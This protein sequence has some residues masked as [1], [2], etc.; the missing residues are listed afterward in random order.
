MLCKKLLLFTITIL[1][2]TYLFAQKETNQFEK[3]WK[4]IDSLI[5]FQ[6]Q[7]KSALEK[8]N[9]L[10]QRALGKDIADQQI[11]C[12]IYKINL[13]NIDGDENPTKKIETLQAEI[14]IAYNAASKAILNGLIAQAYQHY[15]EAN[16]WKFYNRNKTTNYLKEDITT[17]SADDF[18]NI[19]TS[20]YLKSLKATE[21]LQQ[22]DIATFS[23][24][25]QKGNASHL[26]PTLYDLLAHNALDYFKTGEHQITKPA[27]PFIINDPK[28]FLPS[29]QFTKAS[30]STKDS[31]S[32]LIETIKLFQQLL[33]LHIAR[34][35][36]AALLTVDIERITW[37]KQ[38]GVMR[39]KAILYEKALKS[40]V[41]QYPKHPYNLQAWYL[42]ANIDAEKARKYSPNKDTANRYGF[43]KA[44]AIINPI[45]PDTSIHNEGSA[46]LRNLA[47][48]IQQKEISIQTE[49]VNSINKPFRALVNYKNIDTL[50]YRVYKINED[51]LDNGQ[52][53]IAYSKFI[54]MP[55]M[56][57]S[58]QWLPK[59]YDHQHHSVEIK[60]DGLPSGKYLL[61]FDTTHFIETTAA[62]KDDF[63]F[64]FIKLHISNIA[65]IHNDR[66]GSYV[67]DRETGEPLKNVKVT[68]FDN[69]DEIVASAT[70]NR[71][72]F[73]SLWKKKKSDDDDDERSLYA[74][75]QFKTD[76]DSLF[77][78]KE[79]N[80][81]KRIDNTSKE[82]PSAYLFTD[83]AIY[84]PGQ[85]LFFKAITIKSK[86][87]EHGSLYLQKEK[88]VVFLKDANNQIIDSIYCQQ[89]DYGSIAG[90]F[91]L[92]SS[93]LT[94]QFSITLKK[95][96]GYASFSVEEYKRPSFSISLK[97]PSNS[98]RLYDTIKIKGNATA[99]SGNTLDN[100]VVKYTINRRSNY[101]N[102][103]ENY[104]D[105]Y[106]KDKNSLIQSGDI[107]TDANGNFQ[108]E[109]LA[110]PDSG[111]SVNKK[112]TFDYSVEV[113]I[114]DKGG[115]TR[116]EKINVSVGYQ[117]YKLSINA[118]RNALATN[119]ESFEIKTT[120]YASIPQA[121]KVG[122]KIYPLITPERVIRNSFWSAAD[123]FVFSRK[124]YETYF[125]YDDYDN[126]LKKE[127][128]KL[129]EPIINA[130]FNTD[131]STIFHLPKQL[132]VGYYKIV[133]TTD[134]KS[135][136]PIKAEQFIQL[137]DKHQLAYPQTNFSCVLKNTVAP[138]E[139]AEFLT[140]TAYNKVHVFQQTIRG[141]GG[142]GFLYEKPIQ[143]SRSKG[144]ERIV[145]TP[146][147][148]DRGG[149]AIHEKFVKNGRVYA[150]EYQ[151][152]VPW[153]NKD[154]QINYASYRNKTEP[155]NKEKWTVTVKDNTGGKAAAEIV[156]T[157]YDASLDQ[158]KT[159]EFYRPNIWRMGR[160]YY[161]WQTG[162]G[163]QSTQSQN[164][165]LNNAQESYYVNYDYLYNLDNSDVFPIK[166]KSFTGSIAR[167]SMNDGV[168][169]SGDQIVIGYGS[170]KK[171]NQSDISKSKPLYVVDGVPIENFNPN[172]NAGD[173]ASMEVLND[174]ATKSI[175]GARAANGV[176]I[177][178]TKAAMA[179]QKT[180]MVIRKN[181]N[182]TAFFVP[183]LHADT[184]GNYTISF[185]MPDALT[186]WKW[187][188]F[189]HTKDLQFGVQSANIVSQ[190]TLMVQT[191]APRFLRE[192]DKLE[193]TSTISNLS[194][195]E[196]SGEVSL[197]LVDATTN[198]AVDG[199]FQN[200]FPK[201]YFTVSAKQSTLIKFPLTIPYN[202][203]K[204]MIWKV[205][206]TAGNFSDGEEKTIPIISNRQ[207][208]T[209]TMPILLRGDTTINLPFTKLLNQN[210]GSKTLSN[211]SVTV[212][213]TPNPVWTALQAL[214]YL[215][216]YPY[217]CA[218][219]TF[220]RFFGNVLASNLV[221]KHPA[222]KKVFAKW[223]ND[224]SVLQ[225]NLYK[226]EELKQTLLAETPWVLAAQSE[227]QQQK[228]IALLFDAVKMGN[229][230][231]QALEKLIQ[232]QDAAGWLPW[233]KGGRQDGYITNY[234]L[235]G[236][237]KL[238][239]GG[240]LT[241]AQKT[242]LQAFIKKGVE[243]VDNQ[244]V[245][246]Y[247]KIVELYKK[248]FNSKQTISNTDIDYL[249]M[250]S[251]WLA[252]IPLPTNA[253]T[254]YNYF[255]GQAK[256]Y[257]VKF[258]LYQQSL[259]GLA[260]L[261]NNE[262]NFV[263][264]NILPSITQ[265]AIRNNNGVYWKENYTHHWYESPVEFQTAMI[266]FIAATNKQLKQPSLAVML[267]EMKTW[268]ILQ[269]Q[270][271]NWQTTIAT[272]VAC[273]SLLNSEELINQNKKVII[274]LGTTTINTNNATEGLGY[275]KQRING[276]KV[277]ASMGNI[278]VTTTS[279]NAIKQNKSISY[280]AV[281]WQYFED[282][283]KISKA[284]GPLSVSKKLFIEK[285]SAT[286]KV[287]TPLNDGD[288]LAI[289]DKVVTRLVLKANRD[290]DYIH[291][292]DTR[293]A[294][295]EPE[296]VLSSYKWQDGLGYYE[297]TKDASTNFF[298]SHISSGT[299]VFDY[300]CY[301]THKG[302]FSSGIAS[303]QCM[304]A[305]S[306][307]AHSEGVKVKVR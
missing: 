118:P 291:L 235:I 270:T 59:T 286:G 165:K 214:P 282:M 250:R 47:N 184:S 63:D 133:T 225:S 245:S 132:P 305:P 22:V 281:Y 198:T 70:T 252:E 275:L 240:M 74:K 69:Y 145:F 185:T 181:F 167:V 84:R 100:A 195:K 82:K 49:Q 290:M 155:S 212:E 192:G 260:L 68:A 65:Y 66:F 228:N 45:L 168:L 153:S 135:G 273:F 162:L 175:Y 207:L 78:K 244:Q 249:Y 160:I 99:F 183:Q 13:E 116:N 110:T 264:K 57:S 79:E 208:V 16:R 277:N 128:W 143:F 37:A 55:L 201:Q 137:F 119:W 53:E 146:K 34:K 41:Q 127:N 300:A 202:Y 280:G 90:K 187:L 131:S 8:V 115:E 107:N 6:M 159:N 51:T 298:I 178:T 242:K 71:E 177:I 25:I 91:Q 21:R 220:N 215:M 102:R 33:A 121:A 256:Q 161:T 96:S 197:A 4:E 56:A 97:S 126:D 29:A 213:Y 182:E 15:F 7:P 294:S 176:V 11:K 10:Y 144:M 239:Q 173:I 179:V 76:K 299:Y 166:R 30:F 243:Y 92:P 81:R 86:D 32:P 20:Y 89:N 139:Q 109:F 94:G 194:D 276:E 238:N 253:T 5:E 246:S 141:N 148:T 234:I 292:K 269:K 61:L 261:S 254:A 36:T 221:N 233:F 156:S 232:M 200:S 112:N 262:L 164:I 50:F 80:L 206:A 231:N 147:E 230:T 87:F 12:L 222:I 216:E 101:A 120:N 266:D 113:S 169:D 98:Y 73:F 284:D 17:W 190:K 157:L 271:N 48:E 217:E 62:L 186:K 218:E 114:T 44:L 205:M 302:S 158:F 306:F 134:D 9:I 129:S 293:A 191:N 106:E 210:N 189:A 3:E 136:T 226:N 108:I 105:Y 188:S 1:L 295:L 203:N 304:Y 274:N 42:L 40:V 258:N 199:W 31:S 104:G 257:W 103:W 307:T 193:F 301:V 289:G 267:D 278:S 211:E 180:P 265:N 149:A 204:P 24:I 272:S 142:E 236:L 174:P 229:A 283:D 14:D 130:F 111:I 18:F 303:I 279:D 150:N 77:F 170:V 43:V 152:N 285:T 288:A 117:A 172:I 223:A 171:S 58:A 140:G 297:A 263:E 75:L 35:D 255:Y 125:P 154:L 26:R 28:V 196:L 241:A 287:L 209:E 259:L 38:M 23:A 46:N 151:I 251:F 88:M 224:S 85:T 95:I 72:G 248:D 138:N 54:K 64:N 19:I 60:I 247:N 123:Q 219:Q 237:G 268:L 124:E 93:G 67:V 27:N 2:S 39:N 296:N 83:R 122:I 227:T 163:F 52:Y